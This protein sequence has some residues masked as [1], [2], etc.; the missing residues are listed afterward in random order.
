MQ[1]YPHRV[2]V[3]P[4][5]Q[6]GHTLTSTIID[7]AANRVHRTVQVVNFLTY[8]SQMLL[9][10]LRLCPCELKCDSGLVKFLP[11]QVMTRLLIHQL[12]LKMVYLPLPIFTHPTS[13]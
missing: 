7:R 1:M 3:I 8:S 11:S 13:P 5:R 10:A 2:R 4:P 6:T 9:S 12:K